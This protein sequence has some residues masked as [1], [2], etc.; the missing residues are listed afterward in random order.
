MV[1]GTDNGMTIKMDKAGRIV[2]PKPVR[3]RLRLHPGSD[4]I[5]EQ[6]AEGIMLRPVKQR[7]SLVHKQG[8]LVH[9]GDIEGGLDWSQMVEDQREERI[10]DVAGL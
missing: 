8:L 4:L 5:L 3:D 10:K 7:A 9:R 6:S 1:Y 2:L